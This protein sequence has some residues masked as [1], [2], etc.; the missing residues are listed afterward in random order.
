M[1]YLFIIYALVVI[2]FQLAFLLLTT[3]GGDDV[4]VQDFFIMLAIAVIPGVNL[5]C[6][7]CCLMDMHGK[8]VI[9]KG[10]EK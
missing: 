9:L 10:R 2:I 4:D 8:K 6:A 1:I 5:V 7:V 3:Q